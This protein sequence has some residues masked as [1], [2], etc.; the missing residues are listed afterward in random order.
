M[1]S[2]SRTISTSFSVMGEFLYPARLIEREVE[3]VD[4]V[5]RYL[6][7][8]A[9]CA[10]LATTNQS[11]DSQNVTRVN[12]TIL[13]GGE[14]MLD[15]LILVLDD[16]VLIVIKQL[17]ETVDEVHEA[18]HLL[19]TDG[20]IAR[21]LIDHMDVVVLLHQSANRATHGDHVVIGMWREDHHSLP[22]RAT[23]APDGCCRPH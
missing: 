21:S 17:V 12:V 3:E 8:G 7:V 5:E 2:R 13:L 23:H 1:R 4:M 14:E 19:V 9:R 18:R 6:I 11:L 22:D 15:L 10:R 20:N 16:L